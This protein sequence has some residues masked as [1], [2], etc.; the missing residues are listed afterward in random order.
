MGQKNLITQKSLL[1]GKS[2]RVPDI[3]IYE[4]FKKRSRVNACKVIC[5]C[6]EDKL[7]FSQLLNESEIYA[8]AFMELGVKHG[9]VVPLCVEPSCVAVTLF[10]A[11]NR[12]GAVSTFL[13]ATA[14]VE[15]IRKYIQQFRSNIFIYSVRAK[16]NINA[17]FEKCKLNNAIILGKS[18][19]DAKNKNASKT[20]YNYLSENYNADNKPIEL[21]KFYE[22]G[23]ESSLALSRYSGKDAPAFIA[24]TSGTTGEPKS[25]LLS[26]GNIIAEMIALKKTSLMQ[27]AP[28]GNSLQV[29]P[30]NYPYG[31]IISV[32][33]P[34][35]VGKTAALT[36]AL[37]AENTAEYLEMYK[38]KYISAIPPFYK[39]FLRDK[40]I[41][42]M[43]LSFIRY[44]VSGGDVITK[45]EIERIN[46]FLK[47]RGSKGRLLNGSG[48]GEGCGSLT[49]PVALFEKYNI[50]SIGK[51]IYGLSVKFIDENGNIV[52]RNQEGRFCF[53]GKNVMLG[54][55]NDEVTTR[56]VKYAD[57]DGIEWF[58][59]DTYG[60]MD[61]DN[62]VYFSG[63]ERRFF[64]TYDCCGSP[65]KVY[66]DHVQNIIKQHNNV[67]DCVVVSCFDEKRYLIPVAFVVLENGDWGTVKKEIEEICSKELQ[68]CAMPIEYIKMEGL[69]VL[70]AGK[71]DY[72]GLE[73]LAE[74]KRNGDQE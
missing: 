10:F 65:Y 34:I 6:H 46:A 7:T 33:F 19:A 68:S 63:R 49:N 22:L 24:Y 38:P 69:P 9:D 60:Y 71:I 4:L 59:T 45:Y 62:W 39:S 40:K 30:F 23:Q 26:N 5:R 43:D 20:I 36:P 28:Q 17:L 73:R 57:N 2:L 3:N 44:P 32:L 11:L 15:E 56:V 54:Y 42:K 50:D 16:M 61:K 66:C 14:G 58:H 64:I 53:A 21:S 1:I 13:N 27:Y 70:N 8:K 35:F 12:I 52:N 18:K 55:Y 47:E 25:I 41:C 29:V 51:P 31:F 67:A 48:N 37:T 74:E 72:M